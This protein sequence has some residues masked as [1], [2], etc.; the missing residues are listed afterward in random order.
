MVGTVAVM[1][2]T[3]MGLSMM[4]MMWTQFRRRQGVHGRE[5]RA[6]RFVSPKS[7]RRGST[8]QRRF[9]NDQLLDQLLIK[10]TSGIPKSCE[11]SL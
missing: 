1:M 6:V 3:M 9:G 2:V 11:D 7:W 4:L 5:L 8:Y 10:Q